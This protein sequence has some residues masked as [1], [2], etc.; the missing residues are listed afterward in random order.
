M[1]CQVSYLI[2]SV[3]KINAILVV[4]YCFELCFGNWVTSHIEMCSVARSKEASMMCYLNSFQNMGRNEF[5]NMSH[6]VW[7]YC[8]GM[9][10]YLDLH[11][12]WFDSV[13]VC[14]C[15]YLHLS[16]W[17]VCM[18]DVCVCV[19]CDV[20]VCVCVCVCVG[21]K[22]EMMEQ[23]QRDIR[24]FKAKKDLDKVRYNSS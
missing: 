20:C 15:M 19:W 13:C 18:C 17:C 4:S 21:N 9:Y 24:D 14:M 11:T 2:H 23:I 7:S 3:V 6:I 10:M 22:W 16:L 5:F 1:F 8:A 12:V